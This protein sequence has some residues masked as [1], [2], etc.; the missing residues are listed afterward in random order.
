M[1]RRRKITGPGSAG[2][3]RSEREVSV[4]GERTV[5]FD[6]NAKEIDKKIAAM[7]DLEEVVVEEGNPDFLS[8]DGLL[9]RKDGKKMVACPR[10]RTECSVPEGTT[11]IR[12]LQDCGKLKT[13]FIPKTVSDIGKAFFSGCVSLEKVTVDGAKL[14][15]KTE[16]FGKEGIPEKLLPGILDL[17]KNLSPDA[18]SSYVLDNSAWKKLPAETVVRLYL[19]YYSKSLETHYDPVVSQVGEDVF[20]GLIVRTLRNGPSKK[21]KEAA[22]KFLLRYGG[23][24]SKE[25]RKDLDA[26]IAGQEIS[27]GREGKDGPDASARNGISRAAAEKKVA[28]I[29]DGDAWK[30]MPAETV[31]R[32]Y[33]VCYSRSMENRFEPVVSGIGADV[34]AGQIIKAMQEDPSKKE[35]EAAAKFLLR[36]GGRLSEENRKGL[37][38]RVGGPEL[39]LEQEEI[40]ALDIIAG[41]PVSMTPAEKKVTEHMVSAGLNTKSLEKR[42][43]EYFGLTF[44]DLPEVKDAEGRTAPD[45]V[46][47]WLLIAHGATDDYKQRDDTFYDVPGVRPEA[48]EVVS[49]LDPDSFHGALMKL[50]DTYLEKYQTKKVKYISQPFC[51]YADEKMMAALTGRAPK[52]STS[53]SGDAAP[54]LYQLRKA[55]LYSDTR[56]AMMFADRF[57]DLSAYAGMRNMS[58]EEFRD[59]YLSDTGL[60]E[61][62]GKSYDLGNRTVTARLQSDLSFLVELPD[63][64]TAKSLPR[65]GAD[66]AKYETANAD[67]SEM[68]KAV[69]TILKN[70]SKIFFNAFMGGNSRPADDWK[71]VYL[72]N[73]VLRIA[74]SRIVWTQGK[75][76]FTVR[77]KE[78]TDSFGNPYQ[79]TGRPV[80]VAHPMEMDPDDVRRWQLYFTSH[81][82]K[83]PFEQVWEP[84][85]DPAT[86]RTNR[87]EGCKVPIVYFSGREKH[88]IHSYGLNSYSYGYGFSL[89]DCDLEYK[90]PDTQLGYY[91]A[92]SSAVFTLGKFSFRTYTRRVNHIVTILDKMTLIGRIRKDDVSVMSMVDSFTLAQILEFINIAQEANAVNLLMQLM[93]YRNTHFTDYDPMDELTLEW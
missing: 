5:T 34:F 60:D 2:T 79:M 15:F 58:A 77:G 92:E 89:E 19:L 66:P 83:Q 93:E 61:D 11:F 59:R 54:P 86:I 52:W 22:A 64:K 65:K 32:L 47:A 63:G 10:G 39:R 28:D 80:K 51:R 36:Y 12:N 72:A 56:A 76:T 21:E 41:R 50:A 69:K 53:T 82:L 74:A 85:R 88:G 46:F 84:V 42:L 14:K 17:A 43:K 90:S 4:M 6:R 23:R 73:P 13:L 75:R 7:P 71:T 37:D 3:G 8:K 31:A 44:K 87:Y 33:L 40:D 67:F 91:W 20:A 9:F 35:K 55:A 70:R 57:H 45:F 30:E 27:P 29:L 25:N 38:A 1:R 68:K 18:V 49:L 81:G 48:A 24:L 16:H 78:L 62:G 26:C